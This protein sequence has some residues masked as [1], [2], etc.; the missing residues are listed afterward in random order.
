AMQSEGEEEAPETEEEGEDGVDGE[1][2][3]DRR[4]R[5]VPHGAFH[6]ERERRKAAENE[7]TQIRERTARLEERW[8]MML[9]RA[10]LQ[11][12]HQKEAE[13]PDPETDIFGYARWL[14]DQNKS[15]S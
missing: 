11:P 6:E 1:K 15:L 12:Q 2:Q 14:A 3:D 5:T 13:P 7:L 9:Q 4:Q 10:Q 8:K